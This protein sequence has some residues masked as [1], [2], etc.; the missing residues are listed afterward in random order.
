MSDNQQPTN[1][2]AKGGIMDFVH[3][4]PDLT[5]GGVV[6]IVMI[7]IYEVLNK[8][9]ATPPAA[10]ATTV[11]GFIPT[12]NSSSYNSVNKG[13][14]TST[15]NT[16]ATTTN[17]GGSHRAPPPPPPPAKYTTM[18]IRARQTVGIDKQWDA[19]H[20][21]VPLRSAASGHA[22][23]LKIIPFGSS[24]QVTGSAAGG[25]ANQT[26]GSTSWYPVVG[27]GYISAWDVV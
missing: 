11:T 16:T 7:I 26:G 19:T 21:G 1:A 13:N 5:L 27:G 9:S 2:P 17:N 18:Q 25:V 3:E 24:I 8:S 20:D 12:S 4:H 10:A 6:V 14:V 22:S 23:I 15:V